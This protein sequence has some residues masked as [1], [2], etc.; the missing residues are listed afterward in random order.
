LGL[1]IFSQGDF[2]V[3]NVGNNTKVTNILHVD[4]SICF[5]GYKYSKIREMFKDKMWQNAADSDGW[6]G[7]AVFR[8]RRLAL[9]RLPDAVYF[10]RLAFI[11]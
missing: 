3:I 5:W 1:Q 4:K 7:R 11:V 6:R 2:S 8:N 9:A 10:R